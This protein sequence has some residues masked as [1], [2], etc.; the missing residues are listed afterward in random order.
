MNVVAGP[1][2]VSICNVDA[3]MPIMGT[4]GMPKGPSESPN[5]I[6]ALLSLSLW[7][8]PGWAGRGGHQPIPSL[9]AMRD[10]AAHARRRKF[11]TR[12]FSVAALK[13]YEQMFRKRAGQFVE[14]LGRQEGVVDLSQWISYFS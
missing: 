7:Y 12:A 13:E 9:I 5:T 3:V 2:E 10:P 14:I 1:N 11:W 6:V 4:Q 8:I